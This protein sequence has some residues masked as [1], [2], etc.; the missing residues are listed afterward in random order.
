MKLKNLKEARYHGVHP[1]AQ[2]AI[3]HANKK[4]WYDKSLSRQESIQVLQDL[5]KIL[6][7]PDI[8]REDEEDY[9][10]SAEWHITDKRFKAGGTSSFPI[11]GI[12][13]DHP[14]QRKWIDGTPLDDEDELIAP[15]V[16]VRQ[17][18][19]SNRWD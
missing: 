9:V 18:T 11:I 5:T 2:A 12:I 13:Y 19:D 4:K 14:Q 1:A 16:Y 10:D 8:N 15:E 6:G 17:K 7:K 3:E